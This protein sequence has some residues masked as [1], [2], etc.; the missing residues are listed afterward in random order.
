MTPVLACPVCGARGSVG[1]GHCPNC[2][3]SSFVLFVGETLVGW[4]RS[5]DRFSIGLRAAAAKANVAVDI[6][7]AAATVVSLLP[8]LSYVLRSPTLIFSA[9]L[10]GGRNGTL[11]LFWLAAL[12][13]FVL[14][15]R[16]RRARYRFVP[17]PRLAYGA[18]APVVR[19][20]SGWEEARMVK[21]KD[22]RDVSDSFE[23]SALAAV[24]G[25]VHY[26]ESSV[27]AAVEPI[28][29]FASLLHD[30]QIGILFGRAGIALSGVSERVER[31]LAKR[32]PG[33]AGAVPSIS[34][35][36]QAAILNS[37]ADALAAKEDAVDCARL[38]LS[39]S[40]DQTVAEILDDVGIGAEML[41]NVAAWLRMGKAMRTRI[42]RYRALAALKPTGALDRA[43]TALATPMLDRVSHDLTRAARF[44]HLPFMVDR[45][46]EMAS[47]FRVIEGGRSSVVLVGEPGVG[48]DAMLSGLA[49][50]MVEE[51]V[52]PV[53]SDKRLV[54]LSVADLTAGA[55]PAQAQE[56]LLMILNEV[57]RSRNIVL[58]VQ[59]IDAMSG[60]TEGGVDLFGMF[61]Q[62]LGR[63]YFFCI[64]TTTPQRFKEAIE[65]SSHAGALTRIDLKE[66]EANPCIQIIMAIVGPIEAEQR[67]FFTYP[68]IE[69]AVTLSTRYL[70][71][72]YLPEK[73]VQVLREAAQLVRR[74]R[75][76]RALVGAEDVAV[77]VSEKSHVPVTAV[78]QEET[79][80]LM[81]LEQK[82]HQ[83]VI[84]QDEA[85]KAVASALKRARAE[86]RAKNRPIAS[87]LFLG[88]TG[89]GKT[90]LA[91]TVAAEYFGNEQAM[92]RLDMSEYQEPSSIHRLIGVP[93]QSGGGLLTEAVRKTPFT[94]LLLDEFEKAHPDILNV[95]LQVMEDGRLTDN[96][97]RTIDFTNII[98]VATSN[99]GS[100]F[101]QDAMRAGDTVE[102]VK[103]GLLAEHLKGIF[104]PEL[105]NRFDG[106]IVFRPLTKDEIEQVAWLMMGSITDMLASRG[107]TFRATDE[108]VRELAATGF[109]PVFGARPMRR[110]IQEK[111]ENALA[112]ELLKQKL[113]RRDTVVFEAGGVIRIEKA[114]EI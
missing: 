113:G 104:K 8:M 111:V 21:H 22:V 79:E 61:A 45:E 52:P 95:F 42:Q 74:T 34:A 54:S 33:A 88:P 76:E 83:R 56:R 13:L 23:P 51:D 4:N 14:V 87:F 85:V 59:D 37:Y 41:T 103:A 6:V 5:L 64:S 92:V 11:F 53:L 35:E 109:D 73:A 77:V 66:P 38:M 63:G 108:A 91:K 48:K 94:L 90:E 40:T 32:T 55:T 82:M 58:A 9:D 3:G 114:K 102:Q 26:A 96:Q 30:K 86:L 99:A 75:G 17:I 81:G 80:K 69:S 71:D 112:D 29:L 43:M 15:S 57:A 39:V 110:V 27:H 1:A 60:V 65:T 7:L 89:V 62:E 10:W 84:G 101:I 106:V 12:L 105:L 2:R 20:P 31:A 107:I 68:A 46:Q 78:T 28:H 16:R 72:Q 67:V 100:Q 25:A 36:V 44:G 98:I 18:A 19:T 50:R 49:Q 24:E 70:H 93:G 47:I 97:G